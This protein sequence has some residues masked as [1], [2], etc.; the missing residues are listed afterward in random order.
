MGTLNGKV[1]LVTGASAPK[2]IGRAIAQ[3][4]AKE[5]ADVVITDIDGSFKQQ[6]IETMRAD[7]LQGLVQDIVSQGGS[8]IALTLDVTSARDITATME[9]VLAK[10]GRVDILVNNA[11]S[12]SG[13]DN[14]LSTSPGQ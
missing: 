1:A 3:R 10:F 13:S 11:G 6:D 9:H 2:G 7:L 5:G 4:L 14:F 12:L 8:A